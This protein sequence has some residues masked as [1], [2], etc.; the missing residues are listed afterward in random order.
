MTNKTE[1]MELWYNPNSKEYRTYLNK[2]DFSRDTEIQKRIEGRSRDYNKAL[3]MEVFDPLWMMARQWQYGRFK[4]VDC[5]TPVMVNVRTTRRKVDK[6]FRKDGGD[7]WADFSTDSPLEY[8]VEKQNIEITPFV[9]VESAMQLKKKFSDKE[10]ASAICNLLLK[11]FALDSV[12]KKDVIEQLKVEKNKALNEFMAFYAK[13]SFDGY[14]IYSA[15]K[16]GSFRNIVGDDWA[17]FSSFETI[18]SDYVLWF[19]NKFEPASGLKDCWNFSKLGYE[20]KIKQGE[21]VY[22]AE[23]YDSGNLSWYSYDAQCANGENDRTTSPAK[24]SEVKNLSYIPSPAKFVGA[25][26]SRLWEMENRI[27]NM[28]NN[29]NDFSFVGTAAILQYVTMFSNDWMITPLET[30]MGTVLDVEGI[31]VKD[32]FGDRIYVEN[33]ARKMD[34]EEAASLIRAGKISSNRIFTDRWDLFGSSYENAY[35]VEDFGTRAGMLFPPTVLRCEES[36]PIEE[37]QFLRDEMANMVWGVETTLNNGCGGTM[38][39]KAL[40]DQVFDAI[41]SRNLEVGAEEQTNSDESA[42][43]EE[44]AEN[45][46]LKTAE[47]SLLI[48]NRV[49][50][51]WIPFVP[52]QLKNDCRN[53]ALRR[54]RMPIYYDGAYESIRPSTSLMEVKKNSDGSVVPLYL[55]EEEIYGCG[56]KVVKTAQRTRWFLGKSFNWIGNKEVISEYQA[57]SGLMFDDL[58]R[59]SDGKQIKL[60]VPKQETAEDVTE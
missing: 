52:E 53:I 19:S 1:K 7:G 54:G 57:N 20:S 33:N 18:L 6:V 41:D 49:P 2:V 60:T 26:A 28:G 25:P 4:A 12:V 56:V 21:K 42:R 14:K 27:V 45:E 10:N 47:Y 22:N 35:K 36:K 11:Y 32:S 24:T 59:K 55:N 8:E 48:Q 9:R 16:D 39:G 13:R 15:L 50:M 31:V 30:E 17:S 37:V 46:K 38:D 5:G 34:D 3:S 51:N 29:D 58:I 40:S 23:D 44:I 43:E